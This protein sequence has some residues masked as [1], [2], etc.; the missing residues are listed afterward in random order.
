MAGAAWDLCTVADVQSRFGGSWA[1]ASDNAEIQAI[2]SGV[3]GVFLTECG[4][5]LLKRTYT[6]EM[7]DG[8][9]ERKLYLKQDPLLSVSSL[10]ISDRVI[11]AAATSQF[12]GYLIDVEQGAIVLN[13]STAP[14]RFVKG[15]SNIVVTY[16]AGLDPASTDPYYLGRYEDLRSNVIR[17]TIH[18]YQRRQTESE[19]SRSIG[20]ETVSFVKEDFIMPVQRCLERF[21][22]RQ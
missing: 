1:D 5:Y 18:E 9:D 15:L 14:N 12:P 21:R 8:R 20:G 2:L 19:I 7:Y 22:R 13:P 10:T 4:R 3:S 6:G 11:S 16:V 17:Q